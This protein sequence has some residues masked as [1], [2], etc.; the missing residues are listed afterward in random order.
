MM[1]DR[2]CFGG[3]CPYTD[4]PCEDWKC[5]NCSVNAEEETWVREGRLKHGEWRD[6][7]GQAVLCSCCGRA[8]NAKQAKTFSYC[9]YCGARMEES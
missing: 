9:P 7:S 3:R 4:K 8:S 1:S 5:S 2:E 6:I